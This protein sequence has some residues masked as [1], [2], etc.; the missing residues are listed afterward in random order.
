MVFGL[1]YNYK[2][3]L[4]LKSYLSKAIQLAWCV[5]RDSS[6][7]QIGSRVAESDTFA[8]RKGMVSMNSKQDDLKH[9]VLNT[10]IPC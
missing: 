4:S 5:L 10:E 6:V 2:P 3:N 7:I 1:P 8:Y 9:S